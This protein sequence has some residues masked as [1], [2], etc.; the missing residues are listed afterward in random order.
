MVPFVPIIPA[1]ILKARANFNSCMNGKCERDFLTV[2]VCLH[3]EDY[4]APSYDSDYEIGNWPML[5]ICTFMIL[6]FPAS[7]LVLLAFFI[8]NIIFSIIIGVL[9]LAGA[10]FY[11]KE[12]MLDIISEIKEERKMP[13]QTG[14]SDV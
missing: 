1:T 4:I 8:D 11:V 13:E 2:G 3:C 10:Y 6:V 7:I 12:I 9:I 5:F 14:V